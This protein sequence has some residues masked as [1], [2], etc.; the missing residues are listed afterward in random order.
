MALPYIWN[1]NT[2]FSQWNFISCSEI[3]EERKENYITRKRKR[4]RNYISDDITFFILSKLPLKSL[5]RFECVCKSWA[6][7]FQNNYFLTMYHN[8]LMMSSS[9]CYDDTYLVLHAEPKNDYYIS[10]EFYL[11]SGERL[12]NRVKIDWPPPFQ[13]YDSEIFILGS[14]SING[15]LCLKQKFDPHL[16]L[17]NP[18]TCEFKVVPLSPFNSTPPLRTPY[19]VLHGFGYD[20]VTDDYKVI[21]FVDSLPLAIGDDYF[22]DRSYETFWEIY[23]LRSNSWRRLD[24]CFQNRY[25]Y[26]Q[27]RGIGVY[28]NGVC[29]W[30]AR[31]D[32]SVIYEECLLSFNFSNEVLITTPAPLYLDVNS[33]CFKY[34]ERRLVLLNETVALISTYLET[35]TF[36]ISI[37]GELGVRESWT[38][39]LIVEHLPSIGRPI[40]VGKNSNILFF[41]KT[42]GKLAWVDLSTKMIGEDLGLEGWLFGCSIGKYKKSFLPIGGMDN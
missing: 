4:V 25:Y 9:N 26:T 11:L 42:D 2:S 24:L 1:R 41:Q 36:H 32:V 30:W 39:I 29:H 14:L 13:E 23:S 7:L 37:L 21:Q 15:I 16:V 6:L 22:H 35:G 3:E 5:K 33:P 28:T 38:K 19:Y 18:A 40:G 12:K 20:S 10:S 8:N 34:V 17:W 27:N 31:T